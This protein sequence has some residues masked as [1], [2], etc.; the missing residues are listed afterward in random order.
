MNRILQYVWKYKCALIFGTVSMLIII[1]IDLFSPYLQKI[2]LDRGIVGGDQSVI[3]PILICFAVISIVKA[4]LGYGKEYTYDRLASF[5]QEDIKHSMFNHIQKLEFEYFDN[6]NTGELM[7]RIGE[8]VDNIWDTIGFG[9]RLFIENI[10]YFTVS[11]VILLYLNWQLTIVCLMVMIPIGFIGIKLEKD[12]G[13]CYD[14]LSDK[15]AEINIT[16]EE[17]IAGVRLV[18]AFT[19]EKHEILKFLSM[20]KSYYDLNVKQAKVIGK[21]FPPIE[22]L[23]NISLVIMIVLGGIFVMN[24]K[25]TLGTLVAFNGYIGNVIWPLR[26]LGNLMDLL[27]RSN[28]SA[29]KIFKIIDRESKVYSKENSYKP[30]K[31]K[32]KIEFNNVSFKYNDEIVLKDIDLKIA[33]G[34][35]VALMGTTGSGKSTML[36]LIGR[37]YDVCKGSILIDGIDIRD[38]DLK[39]LRD[40]MSIVMQ[41]TFLF[42]DSIINNIKFSNS[43]ATMKEVEEVSKTACCFE[44]IQEL[45]SGYDTE[46]GERG[47]GL[48]GG[49]KQRISIARALLRNSEILILDD[50]TSALDMETEYKLLSNLN[51]RK[52]KSTTFIIAHRISAVKNADIILYFEGGEIKEKG[53]HEELLQL[54][55]SYYNVYC[56]Q[57]KDFNLF[58]KEVM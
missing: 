54:K 25:M 52:E 35:T 40:N 47:I 15:T 24:G 1:G 38:Y 32:G 36:N 6:I 37:Y 21:Y 11:I 53:T 44:F 50:A 2:F 58:E 49:Q 16:A 26:M 28:A 34:S 43:K 10:I 51:K 30:E 45:E 33:S 46:I 42:S 57:F 18:K 39:K 41:D 20:N 13:K 29:K 5:V 48:S 7:S 55:G 19:R 56:E 4:V 23:T 9:L 3:I 17:N 12:F 22:F 14:E 31:I 8:D 27:S